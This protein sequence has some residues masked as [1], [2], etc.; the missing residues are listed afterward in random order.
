MAIKHSIIK[1][2]YN[3]SSKVLWFWYIVNFATEDVL[4]CCEPILKFSF[5]C[6]ELCEAVLILNLKHS[7]LEIIF[8]CV[9]MHHIDIVSEKML[10]IDIVSEKCF[11]LILFQKNAS[12]WY[13]VR[14]DHSVYPLFLNRSLREWNGVGKWQ[15]FQQKCFVNIVKYSKPYQEVTLVWKSVERLGLKS[16]TRR[17][18][19]EAV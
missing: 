17:L 14:K 3:K 16:N 15:F 5:T 12:Y 19:V 2:M 9:K 10:H 11:I 4:Q 6:Q 1:I 18:H 13:C 8:L 7:S